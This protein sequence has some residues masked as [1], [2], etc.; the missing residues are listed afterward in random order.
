[1]RPNGQEFAHHGGEFPALL[2]MM[3]AKEQLNKVCV[4]SP[5][6]KS[7]VDYVE[8]A[9][10]HRTVYP[11]PLPVGFE[12]PWFSGLQFDVRARTWPP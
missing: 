2:Y 8:V 6:H 9:V 4:L 10:G 1:M 7:V 3:V 11:E 5:R 12:T